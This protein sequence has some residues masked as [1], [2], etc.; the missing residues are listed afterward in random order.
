MP[1]C[2]TPEAKDIM[3]SLKHDPAGRGFTH[4]ATDG[5]LRSFDGDRKVVDYRRLSPAEIQIVLQIYPPQLREKV[6][7]KFVG[8]DGRDVLDEESL[9]N[10]RKELAPLMAGEDEREG[11]AEGEGGVKAPSSTPVG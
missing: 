1:P 2:A 5:V 6:K 7:D 9:W 8:V 3:S 10:P 11:E 4:L